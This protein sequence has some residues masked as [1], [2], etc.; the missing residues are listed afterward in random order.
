M[1]EIVIVSYEELLQMAREQYV[2]QEKLSFKPQSVIRR[3]IGIPV[4]RN[5]GVISGKKR[6]ARGY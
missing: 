3:D 5:I 4:V 1:E 6:A 2:F